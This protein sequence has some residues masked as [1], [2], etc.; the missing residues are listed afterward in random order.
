MVC[1]FPHN[2]SNDAHPNPG[3]VTESFSTT[4]DPNNS[5]VF[6]HNLNIM[7]LNIQSLIPKLDILET[8]MQQ[9]NILVITESWLNPDVRDDD[10]LISNF[11]PPYRKDKADRPGGGVTMYFRS[12]INYVRRA[13]LITGELEALF[14]EII[15]KS[16]KLLLCGVYR[17]PN[18]G[19]AYWDLIENTLDN[20]SNSGVAD[21]VVVGDFNSNMRTLSSSA[22][23]I[24]L[25]SSYNFQ[26]V[27]DEPTYYTEHSSSVI[28]LVLVSE[29]ENVD[30][31]S[32][33]IPNLVRYHCPSVLY[34]K[35]RKPVNKTYIK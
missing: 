32:R 5:S 22:K 12:G 13:D 25:I 29:H 3:P 4:S 7:Q 26:Q 14:V 35:Y 17:P 11:D 6:S 9:Y 20:L 34:L 2:L 8:E 21:I 18:T 1:I 19:N 27:I 23:M 31:T 28:D 16:H 33:F 24:N 30:V 10:L 15:L